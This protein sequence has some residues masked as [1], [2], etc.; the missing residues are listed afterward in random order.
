MERGGARDD[1]RRL[2]RR[3]RSISSRQPPASHAI[4]YSRRNAI[5]D[6]LSSFPRARL[7]RVA[8]LQLRRWPPPSPWFRRSLTS[9]ID[10]RTNVVK[11]SL[12]SCVVSWYLHRYLDSALGDSF[13]TGMWT[14]YS[15]WRSTGSTSWQLRAL[16][17]AWRMMLRGGL[18]DH[19]PRMNAGRS[20]LMYSGMSRKVSP[21]KRDGLEIDSGA[22]SD[23]TEPLIVVLDDGSGG[24]QLAA[25][26]GTVLLRWQH[27][28]I[29]RAMSDPVR[30]QVRRRGGN[31]SSPCSGIKPAF[32]PS[33]LPSFLPAC[34]PSCLPF[35]S[36]LCTLRGTSGS[37]LQHPPADGT[38]GPDSPPSSPVAPSES[39]PPPPRP[40]YAS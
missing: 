32:R 14:I 23:F 30:F 21:G 26:E 25:E 18:H 8:M 40:G 38:R 19:R 33:C 20:E 27:E 13:G 34:P 6:L 37:C 17:H 3:L 31:T 24:S 9:S 15:N 4:R 39:S 35:V 28:Q 10:C 12:S 36:A 29:A 16:S 11:H 1:L 5:T 7:I 2:I 22:S